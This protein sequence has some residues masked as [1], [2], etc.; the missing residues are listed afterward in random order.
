MGFIIASTGFRVKAVQG[1]Q[2]SFPHSNAPALGKRHPQLWLTL[3]I[4]EASR[5]GLTNRPTAATATT[6]TAARAATAT[7]ST[8]ATAT[9]ARATTRPIQV[10]TN[11][12]RSPAAEFLKL[13]LGLRR[14]PSKT[15]PAHVTNR[16]AFVFP[17]SQSSRGGGRLEGGEVREG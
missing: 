4:A 2:R 14:R 5:V 1:C 13:V 11:A 17:S 12:L 9:T 3:A 6:A 10:S 8:A 7:A 16:P 15:Q